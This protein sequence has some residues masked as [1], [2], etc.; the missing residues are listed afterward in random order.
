MA[1]TSVTRVFSGQTASITPEQRSYVEIF[2]VVVDDPLDD[3]L[4]VAGA[5]GLPILGYYYQGPRTAD[6]A[7][8][9]KTIV[10]SRVDETRTVWLVQCNYETPKNAGSGGGQFE[11][12]SNGPQPN[13]A[14]QIT[15]NPFD[16]RDRVEFTHTIFGAPVTDAIIRSS[17][18]NGLIPTR[19]I[20]SRGPVQVASGEVIDPP[21]EIDDAFGVLR[22]TK[23]EQSWGASMAFAKPVVNSD[24]FEIRHPGFIRTIDR[25]A[26]KAYPCNG[27]LAWHTTAANQI[28]PYWQNVYEVAFTDRQGGWRIS[29][30]NRGYNRRYQP[31]DDDGNGGSVPSDYRTTAKNKGLALIKRLTDA[32]GNPIG[33]LLLDSDG[34]PLIEG[35]PIYIPYSAYDEV[36]FAGLALWS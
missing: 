35:A 34:K 22:I 16:W 11:D 5:P 18:L 7:A 4:T 21:P 24:S 30:L 3:Q 1:V 32:D 17:I 2:M 9:L 33:P 13:D 8:T 15:D 6:P 26:A 20:N 25:Y 31:G 23:C 27:S 14:G 10:P 28:I 36:P 12:S 29:E 19:A